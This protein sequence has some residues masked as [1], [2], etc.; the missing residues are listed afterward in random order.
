MNLIKSF[1][2]HYQDIGGLLRDVHSN[3]IADIKL[4]DGAKWR[5]IIYGS[6]A[7]LSQNYDEKGY[8]NICVDGWTVTDEKEIEAANELAK[9]CQLVFV[10][11]IRESTYGFIQG[12]EFNA[13]NNTPSM[14]KDTRVSVSPVQ[15][16]V[17]VK[18][19]GLQKRSC[20]PL[21]MDL[22]EFEKSIA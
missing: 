11:Y 14:F 18:I 6:P 1:V 10:H 13:A 22:E 12:V 2:V 15:G 4:K 9:N 16:G 8:W 19:E 17:S 5:E 20:S 7:Q 3:L 21:F